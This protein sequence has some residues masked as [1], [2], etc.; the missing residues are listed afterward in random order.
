MY[1]SVLAKN[2]LIMVGE[3]FKIIF[4]DWDFVS[5]HGLNVSFV[6]DQKQD[7][8][9][10]F[11][12][13]M[14]EISQNVCWQVNIQTPPTLKW[15]E[16]HWLSKTKCS[17]RVTFLEQK[18]SQSFEVKSNH[19]LEAVSFQKNNILVNDNSLMGWCQKLPENKFCVWDTQKG[20]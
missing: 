20:N 4:L 13:I 12:N 18:H 10:K 3:F 6:S 19:G 2:V 1:V 11:A 17:Q 7:R 9:K 14:G 16:K 5:P 15:M 8:T